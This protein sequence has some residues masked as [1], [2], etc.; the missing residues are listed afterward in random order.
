MLDK[1]NDTA[2]QW[3]HRPSARVNTE[4]RDCRMPMFTGPQPAKK[5]SRL[6]NTLADQV[7]PLA[8]YLGARACLV[9]VT[10]DDSEPSL[11]KLLHGWVPSTATRIDGALVLG[12]S[13]SASRPTA[14]GGKSS[15]YP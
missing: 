6:R 13:R 9:S 8:D 7:V 15:S 1:W 10:T 12:L 14:R 11:R 2:G 5:N 4:T 3:V